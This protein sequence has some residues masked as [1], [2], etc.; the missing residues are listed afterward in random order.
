MKFD[1]KNRWS[2]RL[3]SVEQQFTVGCWLIPTKV[4][5]KTTKNGKYF[6]DVVAID[7][8]MK[9]VKIKCWGI[10]NPKEEVLH[11]NR[12]YILRSCTETVGGRDKDFGINYSATWGLSTRAGL[13]RNWRLLG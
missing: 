12:I 2:N 5:L 13:S 3:E 7:S 4:T 1:R 9:E 10:Q 6:Y 11:T 8:N